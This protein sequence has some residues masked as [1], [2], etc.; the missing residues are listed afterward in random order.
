[1]RWDI[2]YLVGPMKQNDIVFGDNLPGGLVDAFSTQLASRQFG[3][4]TSPYVA[5]GVGDTNLTTTVA[6]DNATSCDELRHAAPTLN[7]LTTSRSGVRVPQ[8]PLVVENTTFPLVRVHF[9]CPVAQ[10]GLL[11][12]SNPSA[13]V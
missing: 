11:P 9:S 3:V 10:V 13:C 12:Y 2:D 5:L 4:S 6:W 7:V 8:R 1:M